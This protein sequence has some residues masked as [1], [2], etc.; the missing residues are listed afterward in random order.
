MIDNELLQQKSYV[1]YLLL[2]KGWKPS[3]LADEAGIA[4]STL[5]RLLNDKNHKY[6]LSSKTLA[7]LASATDI[8]YDPDRS[9][10][11]VTLE[12]LEKP[13]PSARRSDNFLSI[14]IYDIR[15]SAGNGA[16]AEDGEPT[17]FQPY[18]EQEILRLTRANLEDLAVIQVAGDSMWET[19]HDG[20]KVLVDRTVNRI[21]RDG[22][23]IL[24]FEDE[25]LVKRC[26]RDL[27]NGNVI[28]KSDNPAYD[29]FRI[30]NGDQLNVVG[31]VIWIGRA[32]G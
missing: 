32:L 14:P 22:I 19:L 10:L 4:P 12:E 21:V 18:R 11:K 8:R 25:L 2:V 9:Y 17:G 20:D 16:F 30:T 7:K 1:R 6:L 27:E 26:Q 5:N 13:L 31:R 29:S 24:G 28:V 15:A 23:Y 3:N